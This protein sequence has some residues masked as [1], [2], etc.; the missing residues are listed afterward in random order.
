MVTSI[1]QGLKA[2]GRNPKLALLLWAWYALIALVPVLPAYTWLASAM[3]ASPA[4]AEALGRFSFGLFGDLRNYD[5]SSVMAV[6]IAGMMAGGVVA[7]LS[8]ALVMGG[9]LEVCATDGDAEPL[10]QRFFRGAGRYFPRFLRLA[11]VGGACLILATALV[12]GLVGA[13]TS[14]MSDTE[15]EG[16][17]Y[18]ASAL[19]MLAAAVTAALFLL[20]LD[21][22]RV[23]V[24]RDGDR[25]VVR[26]YFASLG[27]VLRHLAATYVIGAV[28]VAIVA[29]LMLGYV[30]YE[31]IAPTA[32]TSGAIALLFALQQVTVLGRVFARVGLVAAERNYFDRV[33]PVP[34]PA[35]APAPEPVPATVQ[36]IAPVDPAPPSD[37]GLSG[38]EG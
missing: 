32:S 34:M 29:A 19:T 33:S 30:A 16:G 7:L 18:L 21:Y 15:W 27:F 9:I 25:Q 1:T 3:N 11:V 20:A 24:A 38:V 8:S 12:S 26:T 35:P 37:P 6:L 36:P 31:T 5:Q 22:A 14:P 13:A 10:L 4:A 2:V 17:G 23:R 28:F